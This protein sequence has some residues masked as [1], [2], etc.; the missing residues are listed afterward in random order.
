MIKIIKFV[1][2]SSS[3]YFL[4][5]KTNK[6][7]YRN[8]CDNFYTYLI[9][10]NIWDLFWVLKN[11]IT[12]RMSENL[13][14]K[15]LSFPLD[16][17]WKILNDTKYK[18]LFLIGFVF[19]IIVNRSFILFKKLFLWPFKLG[20]FSF[21]YS[22]VGID[23]SWFLNI[24]NFFSVNIPHWVY[25]QYINLFN[26]WLTWWYNT[27]NIKSITSI[28]LI[29]AKKKILE[30]KP[31]DIV[32]VQPENNNKIWYLVGIVTFVV[33][34]GFILWYFDVFSSSN[35]GPKPKPGPS[36]YAGNVG[37]SL[38][39]SALNYSTFSSGDSQE[40][41]QVVDS[42]TRPNVFDP[43]ED[44]NNAWSQRF[45]G[46]SNVG[47]STSSASSPWDSNG[48]PSPTGSND[49]GGTVTLFNFKRGF[50]LEKPKD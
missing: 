10:L 36:G 46:P 49:S 24:W 28:P 1:V 18:K 37:F 22:V 33:G 26:N 45:P 25:V 15:G 47:A 38:R 9:S 7:D 19:T 4:Y 40:L 13:M 8:F 48:P 3:W 34:F 2:I 17:D 21:V 20:I 32:V 31:K 6:S 41:I 16:V 50:L 29:E 35:P 5:K 43:I 39:E 27:V 14:L 12:D 23:V 44:I 30:N 11:F 42:Q